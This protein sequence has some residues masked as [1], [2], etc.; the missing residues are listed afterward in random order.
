MRDFSTVF[1]NPSLVKK[2]LDNVLN[3]PGP[4]HVHI[5]EVCGG[6]TWAIRRWGLDRLLADRVTF[7]SGPGCPVCV[8]ST[9]YV[10]M[11][12]ALAQMPG[13]IITTFGDMIRVPGTRASLAD[14]R[15]AGADVRMV[16]SPLDS[17]GIA[18]SN[19]TKRVIFLGIGFE[20]TSPSIA[21]LI[22]RAASLKTD[23]LFILAS[24]PALIPAMDAV[25]SDEES[26]IQG[27]LCPGHV[28]AIIGTEPYETIVKKHGIPCV[29]SGFEPSDIL[30]AAS[31]ILHQL[32]ENRPAVEDRYSRVVNRK[33][34]P[35]ALAM[36]NRVFRISDG[37]WR[38]LGKIPSSAYTI[39]ER[40]SSCDAARYFSPELTFAGQTAEHPDC[41][42]AMVLR[43]IISPQGFPLFKRTCTPDHPMGACMVSSE[44][45][46]AAH[47]THGEI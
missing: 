25:A 14:A 1:E 47:Y 11:A 43:G 28:S 21:A 44:G 6:H 24:L 36:L 33:G 17:L 3:C 13:T 30:L 32:S 38:G 7:L 26:R 19:Q 15:A 35:D 22:L 29:V 39:N 10:N 23:N 4:D 42:C 5:M 41:R 45:A 20:T 31:R 16:Y 12:T 27:F 18:Q 46:C 9:G 2:L 37:T 40:Y 34:N 8:A